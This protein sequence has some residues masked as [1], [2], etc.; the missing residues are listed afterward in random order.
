[1]TL[2]L[3]DIQYVVQFF[4]FGA[5]ECFLAQIEKIFSLSL[6]KIFYNC[7]GPNFSSETWFY[8]MR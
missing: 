4:L 1:M 5:F 2:L 8:D 7:N 3:K 6:S